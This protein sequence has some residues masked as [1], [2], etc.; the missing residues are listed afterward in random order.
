M[1]DAIRMNLNYKSHKCK[2]GLARVN[3]GIKFKKY[4]IKIRGLCQTVQR[5]RNLAEFKRPFHR[6][7]K[8]KMVWF[9][10]KCC[11]IERANQ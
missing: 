3:T 6:N 10:S 8:S 2:M 1:Q 11:N 5:Q 7:L 9:G 4:E